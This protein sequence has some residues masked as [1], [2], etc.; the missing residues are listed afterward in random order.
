MKLQD[1]LE[2]IAYDRPE[3][4]IKIA[5]TNEYGE[6]CTWCRTFVEERNFKEDKKYWADGKRVVKYSTIFPTEALERYAEFKVDMVKAEG[7]NH[8]F[9]FAHNFK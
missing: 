4:D 7:K 6:E 1:M 2:T 9:I 3:V 5:Y 8:I